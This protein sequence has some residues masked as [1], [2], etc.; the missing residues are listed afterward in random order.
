MP[1][2]AE[3]EAHT[4]LAG[5]LSVAG[6]LAGDSG[7]ALAEAARSAFVDGLTVA[8]VTAAALL[9][10]TAVSARRLLAKA[11]PVS[12]ASAL[13]ASVPD[14]APVRTSEGAATS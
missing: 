14:S 5:T 9:A 7:R 12:S 8:A 3:A 2:S 10:V 6:G 11:A 4:G 1:A 13:T